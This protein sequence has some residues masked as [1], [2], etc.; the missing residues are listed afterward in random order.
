VAQAQRRGSLA[1]R[2]HRGADGKDDHDAQPATSA[3]QELRTGSEQ[4]DIDG[5]RNAAPALADRY[6][7]AAAARLSAL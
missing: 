3:A 7:P 6:E 2:P 4:T 5:Y 1:R